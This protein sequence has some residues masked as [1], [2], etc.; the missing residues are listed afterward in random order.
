MRL[1]STAKPDEY[2]C[3]LTDDELDALTRAA[4]TNRD[5]LILQIGGYV[6]LHAFEIPQI[7]PPPRQADR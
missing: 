3:W 1:E 4:P 6:G 5:D 2:N 7:Q